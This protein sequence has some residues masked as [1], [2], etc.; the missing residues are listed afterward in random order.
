M[1]SDSGTTKKAAAYFALK[2]VG[3]GVGFLNA[4]LF[5]RML[6]AANYGVMALA[7]AFSTLLGTFAA[8][9][10]LFVLTKEVAVLRAELKFTKVLRVIGQARKFC[11]TTSAAIVGAVFGGYYYFRDVADLTALQFAP[12][13][14]VILCAIY[15]VFFSLNQVR[16]G[17]LRGLN[18]VILADTPEI[19]IRPALILIA[20]SI[21]M[22]YGVHVG[23]AGGFGLQVMA[24]VLAF[25][26][27]WR[28]LRRAVAMESKSDDG[29]AS[30]DDPSGIRSLF[31]ASRH[32]VVISVIAIVDGQISL[33]LVDFM[34]SKADVGLYQ[35]A[36]QPVNIIAMG[37]AAAGVS[38][39][40]AIAAS[41][42]ANRKDATQNFISHAVRFSS[43]TAVTVGLVL[44]SSA[45]FIASLYGP[46]FA[47]SGVLLR[48]L[49]VGQIVHG[50]TGPVGAVLTMTGHQK[51]AFYID[52][53]FLAIRVTAIVVGIHFLGIVGA[54]LGE[55]ASRVAMRL[56]EV[57][58]TYRKTGLITM[59]WEGHRGL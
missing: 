43:L 58:F 52:V 13:V 19:I 5:A 45:T 39:Q 35:A 2:I 23:A 14:L 22:G 7:L 33:Y 41:W 47:T 6:G 37:V 32:L 44:M 40:P 56:T 26:I 9:G 50:V 28:M 38:I 30:R 17:G 29:P 49:T 46:G 27:G 25:V 16:S 57:R 53:L 18:R 15:I 8:F 21:I 59:I 55:V 34:L 42:A 12:P 51:Q 31:T 11:L 4:I 3:S 1:T 10:M 36:L 48:I 20:I 54:A 24:V